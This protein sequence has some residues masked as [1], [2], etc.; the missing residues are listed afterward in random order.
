[1]WTIDLFL[2]QQQKNHKLYEHTYTHIHMKNYETLKNDNQTII[3]SYPNSTIIISTRVHIF[4]VKDKKKIEQM[5][6]RLTRAIISPIYLLSFLCVCVCHLPSSTM[7]NN[8]GN[9]LCS[10]GFHTPVIINKCS[11]FLKC[12]YLCV[13]F[14]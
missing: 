12:I 6:I 5:W 4:I 2:Q 14:A 8:Y 9:Y 7:R 13:F 1:M 3:V 11:F 10:R